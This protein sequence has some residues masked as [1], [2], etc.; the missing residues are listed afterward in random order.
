VV[1][2]SINLS[3]PKYYFLI[4]IAF[5]T[6]SFSYG[7]QVIKG[8]VFEN[9]TRI[10]LSDIQVQNQTTKQS[11]ATDEKGRFSIGAKPGDIIIFKGFAYLPDTILLTD[12]HER[13]IFLQPHQ[14]FLDEVKVRSDT[15]QNLNSYYD[16]EFHGQ[17]MVYQRDANLNYTG[18]IIIRLWYWKKD[19]HKKERLAKE[20]KED[21]DRD[22]VAKVFNPKTIAQFVPLKGEDMDDF[23]ILY[24]P[25]TK[26]YFSNDFNLHSY[27]NTCYQ[28][29]LKLPEDKRHPVKLTDTLEG[30]VK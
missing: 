15:T 22:R 29:Y 9:K 30:G 24:T 2:F 17:T 14:N 19:A 25:N 27:L 20:L 3:M 28:K 1:S 8:R 4:F 18:G 13:E 11:T 16:P 10:S 26:T 23:L 12:T 21:E 7:Q 5:F 6:S